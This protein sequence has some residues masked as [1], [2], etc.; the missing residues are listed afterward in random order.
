VYAENQTLIKST[1]QVAK[2]DRIAVQLKDGT[3]AC[4]IEDIKEWK[5]NG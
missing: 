3:L 4:K 5:D 2:G 1:E